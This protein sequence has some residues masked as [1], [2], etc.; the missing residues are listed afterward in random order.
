MLKPNEKT[1]EAREQWAGRAGRRSQ[2]VLISCYCREVG[3][4]EGSARVWPARGLPEG[5]RL[6][7]AEWILQVLLPHSRA[8]LRVA[9]ESPSPTGNYVYVS[10]VYFQRE[11]GHWQVGDWR[12]VARLVLGEL[13]DR[14]AM[15]L[16]HELQLQIQDSVSVTSAI[17]DSLATRPSCEDAFL[18][19]EQSLVFGHSFHPAPK[20][21]VGFSAADVQRYSP[22]VASRF[23]LH[24]FAVRE[25]RLVQSSVAGSSTAALMRAD[26]EEQD[27]SRIPPGFE[28]LPVHP[29]QAAHLLGHPA[30]VEAVAA[31]TLLDLGPMGASFAATSSVRTMYAP[32]LPYFYKC[33]LH[34]RITNC[35][36][37]NAVYE[38]E[39]SLFATRALQRVAAQLREHFP[40]LRF[41]EE[42]A[43]AT[44]RLG[45]TAEVQRDLEERFAVILRE[46]LPTH[47]NSGE[48]CTRVAGA[49]FGT[50]SLTRARLAELVEQAGAGAPFEEAADLW[51]AGYVRELLAPVLYAFFHHGLVHEA[52]LQNTLLVT[53]RGAPCGLVLRDLEGMKLIPE[54]FQLLPLASLG[55][56]TRRAMSYDDEQGWK[57]VAYCLFVNNLS[58]AIAAL[59]HGSQSLERKLWGR[60]RH[61]LVAFQERFGTELSGRRLRP[62][63][64]GEPFPGKANLTTRFL[65]HADRQA[66]YVPVPNPLC[67]APREA[68]CS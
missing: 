12:Q 17:L 66:S 30:V 14:Y 18:E 4:G 33:S 6:A 45:D 2:E 58:E 56:E 68:P 52:H 63:I 64:A 50:D 8:R 1:P 24:Y 19:S 36:R 49:L 27:V 51:F 67:A 11:G 47:L 54:R 53:E 55:E 23:Q 46:G 7:H 61:A 13:E 38:L 9:V 43:Y 60:V 21:R 26:L 15:P 37:K 35:L 65:K 41:L 57:R 5:P 44:A 22:E 20:S 16:Q 3:R 32:E 25:D 48:R 40:G 42:P 28:P 62:L 31:G 59:G 10:P 39:G 29:W 34:V